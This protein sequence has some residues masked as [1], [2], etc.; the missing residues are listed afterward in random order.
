MK[1]VYLVVSLGLIV[2]AGVAEAEAE[3]K[4]L[5]R[6]QQ[7]AQDF[8]NSLEARVPYGEMTRTLLAQALA[9]G[10]SETD[11]SWLFPLYEELV[12]GAN[13]EK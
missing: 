1:T 5:P 12:D 13:V 6:C 9:A 11:F 8:A 2:F 4:T 3:Q 10:H 7:L